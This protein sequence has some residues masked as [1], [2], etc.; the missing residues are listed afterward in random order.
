MGLK[1]INP[2]VFYF[3]GLANIGI[4]IHK[5][6]AVLIDTGLDEGNAQKVLKVLENQ[7]VQVQAI[8][9]THAHADHFGGN[10]FIV[11]KTGALVYAPDIEE[12][13][14]RNPILEPFYLFGAAPLEQLKG[15]F[16]MAQGS[17]VDY[18]LKDKME[19]IGLEF[20]CIPIPGHSINQTGILV[21]DVFFCADVVFPPEVVKKYKI[22]YC[23]DVKRQK[24]TLN[25]LKTFSCKYY[26][27]LHGELSTNISDPIDLNL[28]SF[29]TLGNVILEILDTP[30]TT[31]EIIKAV[32]H[33]CDLDLKFE[34]YFLISNTLKSHLSC[35]EAE[36]KA[37]CEVEKNR[38]TWFKT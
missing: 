24:E 35:L 36:G 38:L 5:N 22:L 23:Y 33:A 14:I 4:V 11:K 28:K 26:L 25:W 18:I 27:P 21:Q 7:S 1:Q 32:A 29:K 37:S 16:L 34:Q 15:K 10:N 2:F 31:E 19:I 13:F 17:K 20:Q 12:A 8:I 6:E 30:Q 3:Q 9:N